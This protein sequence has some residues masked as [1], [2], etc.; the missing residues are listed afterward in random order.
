MLTVSDDG[1]GIAPEELAQIR[2]RL[3]REH[4]VSEP[5]HHVGM[6]NVHER[7]RLIYGKEYGLSI[8]ST[9]GQGTTIKIMIPID[10]NVERN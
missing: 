5:V 4:S 6:Q 3:Q 9:L 7:L 10:F 1:S 2:E 8:D